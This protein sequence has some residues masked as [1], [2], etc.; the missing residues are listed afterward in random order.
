[1][2]LPFG[3]AAARPDEEEAGAEGPSSCDGGPP[4]T[5]ELP[6]RSVVSLTAACIR[7]SGEEMFLAWWLVGLGQSS[8]VIPSRLSCLFPDP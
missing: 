1:M 5:L 7:Y 3:I 4:A 2:T 8:A 6:V